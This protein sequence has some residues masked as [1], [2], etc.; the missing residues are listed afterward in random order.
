MKAKVFLQSVTFLI[1]VLLIS[2]RINLPFSTMAEGQ[3]NGNSIDVNSEYSSG[4]ISS[5][6]DFYSLWYT[7]INCNGTQ[8]I[9][10][11]YNSTSGRPPVATLFGQRYID[12]NNEEL[13]VGNILTGMEIY[14]ASGGNNVPQ[15]PN[16]SLYDLV[17]NSSAS[18]EATPVE[19]SMIQGVAHYTWGV[20][21]DNIDGSL[22]SSGPAPPFSSG[23]VEDARVALQY[24]NFSFDF[25]VQE[26][27]S[28]LKTSFGMGPLTVTSSNFDVTSVDGLS[29]S[30]L[31]GTTVFT[32]E[33]YTTL[34][35]GSPYNSTTATESTAPADSGQLTVGNVTA[36]DFVFGQNYTLLAGSQPQSI[37]SITV[38]AAQESVPD[39]L[40]RSV[41]GLLSD[42]DV[43]NIMNDA[44]SRVSTINETINLD[45]VNASFLYR[46]C[47]PVWG[48][49][50]I[51]QDP[52]YVAHLIT[53]NTILPAASFPWIL[54]ASGVIISSAVLLGAVY[55]LKRTRKIGFLRKLV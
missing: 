19:K 11:A 13:F 10:L 49:S 7:W 27:M 5:P 20:R 29:L 55:D 50:A 22:V 44:I 33:N 9:Y 53:S 40:Y 47:Y 14:N 38:G 54:L 25:S 8:V 48:G 17:V 6:N 32:T 43:D 26:N 31:Y 2:P 45:S 46:V 36:Y 18:L 4:T 3:L 37:P 12:E 28:I 42:S 35:D 23:A 16:G 39:G 21:Y 34:I 24:L 51:E 1:L 15:G 52:E 30:L 41:E